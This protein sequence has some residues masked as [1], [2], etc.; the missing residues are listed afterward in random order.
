MYRFL[1]FL[2]YLLH[3]NISRRRVDPYAGHMARK[4]RIHYPGA[5]YHVTLRGNDRQTIFFH[6]SDR[7]LWESV[8]VTA[9][10]RYG[11]SIHGY[12]WMTNHMHLVVQVSQEPLASTIR[13]AASQY[14]RKIN[15]REQRTG[16]LFERR[17]GAFLVQEDSYLKGLIRYIH[18]NPIRADMVK[19]TDQYP[20]SSHLAYTGQLQKSWLETRAVLRIFGTT[21]RIAQL[22]YI[23]FMQAN[24]NEDL[25]RYRNGGDEKDEVLEGQTASFCNVALQEPQT[26]TSTLESIIRHNLQCNDLTEVMLTG[27]SRARYITKVRTDIAIESLEQGIA[28][29][30]ELSRR[31]NRSES[32]I[33]QAITTRKNALRQITSET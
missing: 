24:D 33:S 12:C 27:P 21:R 25:S 11:A 1:S 32:A 28:N 17:H 2:R 18:N 22:R 15:L 14:S 13:Y 31:L 19:N 20:W 23:A 16:H 6:P 30:A 9:L 29:I 26:T 8:L 4:P 3:S 7:L 5:L 10:D